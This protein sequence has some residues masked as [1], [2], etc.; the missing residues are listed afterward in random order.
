MLVSSVEN[1]VERGTELFGV[2]TR[3]TLIISGERLSTVCL[4]ESEYGD[5]ALVS[6]SSNI[7]WK[8]SGIDADR[9]C[10]Q[11]V[12]ATDELDSSLLTS[13]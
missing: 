2:D 10:L 5:E 11:F 3:P 13:N 6:E 4:R 12:R 7:E 8:P 9:F 1:E